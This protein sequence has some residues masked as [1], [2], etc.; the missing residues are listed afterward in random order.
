MEQNII[1][2]YKEYYQ[3]D[4]NLINRIHDRIMTYLRKLIEGNQCK[5]LPLVDMYFDRR[6]YQSKDSRGNRYHIHAEFNTKNISL[7]DL[8]KIIY[9]DPNY[10]FVEE[11]NTTYP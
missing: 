1:T 5:E 7:S 3:R 11:Y 8:R 9:S 6:A 10:I 4:L 2:Y